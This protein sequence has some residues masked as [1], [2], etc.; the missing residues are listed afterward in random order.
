MHNQFS[1]PYLLGHQLPACL[2][3]DY[4][5]WDT[6]CLGVSVLSLSHEKEHSYMTTVTIRGVTFDNQDMHKV[7][8]NQIRNH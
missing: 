5:Y 7:C 8:Y 3:N 6:G 1:K 2:L 4:A